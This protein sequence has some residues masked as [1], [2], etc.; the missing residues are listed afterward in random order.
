MLGGSKTLAVVHA[1]LRAAR[2]S[3]WMWLCVALS[4]AV[5][6]AVFA[7]YAYIHGAL[8]GSVAFV[9]SVA[10][11]FLLPQISVHLLWPS[12]VAVALLGAAQR[13]RDERDGLASVL[14]AKPLSTVALVG[15][16]VAAMAV[17]GW[18]L[19]ALPIGAIHGLAASGLAW[20][21]NEPPAP[22]STIAFLF[23]DAPPALLFWVAAIALLAAVLP[24]PRMGLP[25][26][27]ALLGIGAWALAHTPV[28]LLAAFSPVAS[29]GGSVSDLA[30]RSF[31]AVFFAQRAALVLLAGAATL[32]AAAC[33][34][35]LTEGRLR[36]GLGGVMLFA[37]G[38]AGLGAVAANAAADLSR[39]G[40]WLSAHREAAALP[41][42]R[43]DVEHVEGR[44]VI[45]PGER[46]ELD[47]ALR[48]AAPPGGLDTLVF[49]L[50]PGMGVR[51][52]RFDGRRL[53]FKHEHG[54]L[55]IDLPTPLPAGAKAT[56]TVT[57]TGIPNADFAY[58]DSL[59]D[60]RRLPANAIHAL[61]TQAS[62][63]DQRFVA[64]MPATHWLPT[65]GASVGPAPGTQ[66]SRDY[67]R[68]DLAV[69]AP[70]GWRVAGPGRRHAADLGFRFRP[71]SPV[72]E[73]GLFAAPFAS[74]AAEAA[75]VKLELLFHAGHRRNVDHFADVQAAVVDGV[76]R[77]LNQAAGLGLP[78]PYD[79]LTVV[80]VPAQLRGYGGGWRMDT[81]QALPGVLAVKETSFPLA[82][83]ARA[84]PAR[85]PEEAAGKLARLRFFFATD[86]SG[87][88]FPRGLSRNLLRFQTSALGAEAEALDF[89]CEEMVVRL[90]SGSGPEVPPGFSAR[91]F[92]RDAG[93]AKT[94][95]ESARTVWRRRA[96]TDLAFVGRASSGPATWDRAVASPLA[97][98]G[99]REELVDMHAFALRGAAVALAAVD[100]LG[101]DRAGALLAALRNEYRGR[102]F[103]AA[104]LR[105]VGRATGGDLWALLGDWLHDAKL[106][107]FLASQA[108]A[109]RLRDDEQGRSRYQLR[110]HV[111]NGEDVPGVARLAAT[112]HGLWGGR[113]SAPFRIPARA[114]SEVG[115]IVDAP[116]NQLWLVPY[117]SLN[118]A[119]VRLELSAVE[120]DV[121]EGDGLSGARPS[122]WAPALVEGVVVDDLD[123]GFWIWDGEASSDATVADLWSAWRRTGRVPSG[124]SRADCGWWRQEMPSGWGKYR[125]TV[126]RSRPGR[127]RCQAVFTARLPA[128]GRWR[129]AFHVPRRGIPAVGGPGSGLAGATGARQLYRRLGEYDLRLVA[130][131]ESTSLEFD[132]ASA[133]AGWNTL[134]A[135]DLGAHT[136]SVVISNRTTGDVVL[137]DAVHWQPVA[138]RA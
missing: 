28:Y 56:L 36:C 104:D 102:G 96:F 82:R 46:L 43:P 109:Q 108:R 15:A 12:L 66:P 130:N 74:R 13:R 26:A 29:Y 71:V 118:R 16:R 34:P 85:S 42:S 41:G 47:V 1:E 64:L 98:L 2:R 138:A 137:A 112:E 57:A 113:R 45:H 20:W 116:P 111:Y 17:V 4:L 84:G 123:E 25:I 134:G 44:V 61:G 81:V 105:A 100:V 101:R 35:R 126:V 124:R 39:R 24:N 90:L 48:L 89:V 72:P 135:F 27:F 133:E 69:A 33:H 30:P 11:R 94:L 23:V 131:G 107:G 127:G 120:Q 93:F 91:F 31:D 22:A 68:V 125:S 87:G 76:E 54:L 128:P 53:P 121:A 5:A 38:G 19:M 14:D 103:R 110:A 70:S 122:V 92:D 117:F 88:S 50:N 40:Q 119:P 99:K 60:W 3:V 52:L 49:S 67:F 59:V 9:G 136:V 80:E 10:P 6:P 55:T 77:L 83:F 7:H 95:A 114:S 132:G 63:F 37:L 75:G 79:G 51:A 129:L 73:V 21:A 115:W 65:A 106:P 62:V 18:L 86:L 78:Y 58:L 32:V 8:S 97:A